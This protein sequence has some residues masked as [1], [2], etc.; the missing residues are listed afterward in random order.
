MTPREQRLASARKESQMMNNC[1]FIGR[2]CNDL[3]INQAGADNKVLGIN[4]AVQTS[5]KG[6]NGKY[7]TVFLNCKAWNTTAEKIAQYCK[8]GD[9]LGIT[10]SITNEDYI[11]QAGTKIIK[12]GFN[13]NNFDLLEPKQ[14][15]PAAASEQALQEDSDNIP[16]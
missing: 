12:I 13:I 9:K 7:L 14:A 5:R 6:A 4:F 2:I 15:V 10:A 8:K 16:F 1:N 3:Q 11:N